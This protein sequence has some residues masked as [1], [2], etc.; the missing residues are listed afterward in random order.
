MVSR[1]LQDPSPSI[2][3]GALAVFTLAALH[4]HHLNEANR[5]HNRFLLTGALCA[6]SFASTRHLLLE[7]GATWVN[8]A[9]T[10][11]VGIAVASGLSFI[12]HRCNPLIKSRH[13]SPNRELVEKR[14]VTKESQEA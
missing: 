1:S 14:T 5:F 2:F 7:H 8:L 4:S 6:L 12:A 3:V 13:E 9:Q 11:V 10:L